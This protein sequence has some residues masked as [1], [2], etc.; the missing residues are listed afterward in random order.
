ME[1][2][3]WNIVNLFEQEIIKILN[4]KQL[5]KEEKQKKVHVRTRSFIREKQSF[6]AQELEEELED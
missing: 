4:D 5:T 6:I 3:E 1:D 2:E